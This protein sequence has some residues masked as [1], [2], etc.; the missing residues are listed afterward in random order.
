ML[1]FKI[2]SRE[3]VNGRIQKK[4]PFLAALNDQ[5]RMYFEIGQAKLKLDGF[6]LVVGASLA[7]TA[8]Y[9]G[10]TFTSKFSKGA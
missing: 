2:S 3:Y 5:E 4:E 1:R 8:E 10:K 7:Y 9:C 6:K